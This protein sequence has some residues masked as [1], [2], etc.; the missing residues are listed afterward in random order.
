[1]INT[2]NNLKKVCLFFFMGKEKTNMNLVPNFYFS[3]MSTKILQKSQ[4]N[5]SKKLFLTKNILEKK[6]CSFFYDKIFNN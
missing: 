6:K 4:K 2:K 5:F 1:M 3:L